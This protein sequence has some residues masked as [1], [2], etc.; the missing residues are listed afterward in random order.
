MLGKNAKH[1][2]LIKL[3]Y[4]SSIQEEEK[5]NQTKLNMS[6]IHITQKLFI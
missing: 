1:Y 6:C 5:P 2:S 4:S 3:T